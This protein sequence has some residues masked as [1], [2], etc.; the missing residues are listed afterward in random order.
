VVLAA[1]SVPDVVLGWR[2]AGTLLGSATRPADESTGC[3]TRE[4]AELMQARVKE[5]A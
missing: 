2:A 4:R 1:R 3:A 5:S